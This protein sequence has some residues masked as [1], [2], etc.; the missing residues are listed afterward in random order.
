VLPFYVHANFEPGPVQPKVIWILDLDD[1]VEVTP[2]EPD[3]AH[4]RMI[5]MN[6]GLP[7]VV[8]DATTG[9]HSGKQQQSPL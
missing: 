2:A 6:L 1:Q 9:S 4:N 5:E 8:A 7:E 3:S